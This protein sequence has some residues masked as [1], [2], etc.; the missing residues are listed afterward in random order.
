MTFR[1]LGIALAILIVAYL[2]PRW[3]TPVSLQPDRRLPTFHQV[4]VEDPRTQLEATSYASDSDAVRDRLR[5]AVLDTATALRQKPC[6][7]AVKADYIAAAAAYARARISIAP[8]V[9][10]RTCR[11][12]DN[13]RLELAQKA[14]GSPADRRVREAMRLAHGTGTIVKGDF[15]GDVVTE[16]A[17]L[18]GDGTIDPT[19]SPEFAE[20]AEALRDPSR[21]AVCGTAAAR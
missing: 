17:M 11:Q 3:L 10:T 13:A 5:Q 4:D 15:S 7:Q 8:C 19:A 9:A 18:S 21:M 20:V 16:V 12:S 2:V 6:N 14:F 1:L